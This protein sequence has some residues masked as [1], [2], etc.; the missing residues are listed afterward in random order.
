MQRH[1]RTLSYARL[2]SKFGSPCRICSL[3]IRIEKN[4]SEME[5]GKATKFQM[6]N[7]EK[8]EQRDGLHAWVTTQSKT[9]FHYA[10][11]NASF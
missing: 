10:D 11:Y 2:F 6:K 8:T 3:V 9:L 1:K 4:P 5:A 7:G